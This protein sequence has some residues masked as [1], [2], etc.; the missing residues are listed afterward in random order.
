MDSPSR[1]F[2][3]GTS[4]TE[5]VEFPGIPNFTQ[6]KSLEDLAKLNNYVTHLWFHPQRSPRPNP[7]YSL[8]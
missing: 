5:L 2:S 4:A 1:F 7:S 6:F 8:E 3:P